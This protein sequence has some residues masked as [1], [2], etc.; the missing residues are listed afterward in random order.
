MSVVPATRPTITI[1]TLMRNTELHEKCSTRN[2]PSS[3]PSTA[4][5]P[6]VA[7]HRP[8]ALPR[9]STG[10]TMVMIDSVAGMMKAPPTPMNARVAISWVELSD[11]AASS[12]PRPNT[13]RP[14]CSAPTR[15]K[16]SPSAP[17]V[18]S[19]PANTRT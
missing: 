15:P 3:G 7:D 10:K 13:T 12:D 11:I 9:S 1:G 16:R 18:R 6:A 5:M 14:N 19:R 17:A 8:I 4:A 2:P